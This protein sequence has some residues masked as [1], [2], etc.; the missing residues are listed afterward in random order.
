MD[1]PVYWLIV[2]TVKLNSA[3]L[4]GSRYIKSTVINT[5]SH[6]EEILLT[7]NDKNFS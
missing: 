7:Y 2:F 5:N 6:E 1:H 3:L 4:N